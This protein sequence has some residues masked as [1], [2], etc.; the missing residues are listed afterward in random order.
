MCLPGRD[1]S[2]HYSVCTCVGAPCKNDF[3]ETT[4]TAG[5]GGL[6]MP[7]HCTGKSQGPPPPPAGDPNMGTGP[8]PSP[9]PPN[10]FGP[11]PSPPPNPFGPSPPPP[12]CP[13]KGPGTN[14]VVAKIMSLCCGSSGGGHRRLQGGCQLTVCSAACA[15]YFVPSFLNCGDTTIGKQMRSMPGAR[16]FAARCKQA[17]PPPSPPTNPFGQSDHQIATCS[18]FGLQDHALIGGVPFLRRVFAIT[19]ASKCWRYQ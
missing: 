18:V 5:A 4:G 1:G 16:P 2:T 10:P 12:V 13:L 9:P 19:S 7:W 11:P 3:A 17:L 8:E 14:A 15:K 6:E